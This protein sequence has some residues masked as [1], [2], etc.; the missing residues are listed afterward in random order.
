MPITQEPPK[1]S[2]V[3]RSWPSP[4]LE[5]L[6]NALLQ[7]PYVFFG[8]F[9]VHLHFIFNAARAKA[10][11]GTIHCRVRLLCQRPASSEKAKATRQDESR[12]SR[13]SHG[14]PARPLSRSEE[15]SAGS[16]PCTSKDLGLSRC[17]KLRGFQARLEVVLT[18]LFHRDEVC[19]AGVSAQEWLYVLPEASE[20]V[21][22]PDQQDLT[23]SPGVVV[24][25]DF[26]QEAGYLQVGLER[27]EVPEI[28]NPQ[29][30]LRL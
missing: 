26:N 30:L 20:Q 12:C 29:R 24:V 25:Q 4:K 11:G 15:A 21:W 6:G 5:N 17:R 3:L 16:G 2:S 27:R 19:K 1:Q 18:Q 23:G 9:C 13:E 22:S 28:K 10:H 14:M 8:G 7:L